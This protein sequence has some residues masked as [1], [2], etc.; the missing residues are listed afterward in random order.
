ML[1]PHMGVLILVL[2]APGNG[3]S[4]AQVR[5]LRHGD[6]RLKGITSVD[7]VIDPLA[8][9]GSRCGLAREAIQQVTVMALQSAGLKSTVRENASSAFFTV[10]V[11]A[12]TVRS[13]SQCA[14]SLV[15][16]L[17]AHVEGAQ[18]SG[19]VLVGEMSLIRHQ[20]VVSSAHSA[21]TSNVHSVLRDHLK[22]IGT[23]VATANK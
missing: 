2:S 1:A 9:D 8:A 5:E 7:V 22:A 4:T 11:T 13:G 21:H 23:K 12:T 18:D 3:S 10:Y 6:D 15:T 14:T 17:M 19:S 20:G 16:D